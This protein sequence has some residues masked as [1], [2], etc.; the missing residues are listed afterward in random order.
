MH[1]YNTIYIHYTDKINM[2]K[3]SFKIMLFENFRFILKKF[4]VLKFKHRFRSTF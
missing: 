2:I 4:V 3:I 1:L